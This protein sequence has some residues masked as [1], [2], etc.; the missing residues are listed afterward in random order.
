MTGIEFGGGERVEKPYSQCDIRALE[1]TDFTCNALE[2]E[3]W[4][5]HDTLDN[6]YSRYFLNYLEKED[7]Y[8]MIDIWHKLLKVG[9][10]LEIIVPNISHLLNY[11]IYTGIHSDEYLH[12]GLWG[13]GT[14]EF[15]YARYGYNYKS[16][17]NLLQS[18]GFK[19]ITSL[20]QEKDKDLHI[21]GIK[22]EN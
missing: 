18:K 5:E 12:E 15:D 8:R 19:Q 9:G 6:I 13:S 11:F 22:R 16:L 21:I 20:L 4:V 3:N 1:N 14:H 10:Q 17:S 7:A 2:I